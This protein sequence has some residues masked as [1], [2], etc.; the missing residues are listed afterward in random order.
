MTT[1]RATDGRAAQRVL[2]A[3]ALAAVL[4]AAL[5]LR[6]RPPGVVAEDGGKVEAFSPA[7]HLRAVRVDSFSAAL[8][9]V[10]GSAVTV[11]QKGGKLQIL[12]NWGKRSSDFYNDNPALLTLSRAEFTIRHNKATDEVAAEFA[13]RGGAVEVPTDILFALAQNFAQRPQPS[14]SAAALNNA[15]R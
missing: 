4:L 3:G 6:A 12:L 15:N 13:V 1:Q 2:M 5:L 8:R 14:P 10:H 9:A 7:L 11:S